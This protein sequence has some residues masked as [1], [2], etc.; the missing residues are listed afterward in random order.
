MLVREH[1]TL[2]FKKGFRS[3][4]DTLIYITY[5]K[6]LNEPR[7][8]NLKKRITCRTNISTNFISTQNYHD[9][10]GR[11]PLTI[12]EKSSIL[13]VSLGSEYASGSNHSFVIA[14]AI[15]LLSSNALIA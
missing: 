10:E 7:D 13:A 1:E 5:Y 9:Q 4:F 14:S 6:F 2:S 11:I 3:S 15:F 12:F 8:D